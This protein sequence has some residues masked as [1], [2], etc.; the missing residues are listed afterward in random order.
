[1]IYRTL[2]V[3][4]AVL[5]A[6]GVCSTLAEEP[7]SAKLIEPTELQNRLKEAG[8]RI[9]DTRSNQAY[10]KSHVSGAAWVDVASWKELGKSKGGFRNTGVWGEKVGQLGLAVDSTVVVY[11]S[12]LSDTAR[13]WWLLKYLG[14]E[15][16]VI[17]DGGW[18]VWTEEGRPTENTVPTIAATRF[19]PRFDAD[20]LAEKDPLKDLL[21]TGKVTVVDT[22]SAAEFTGKDVRGKRGGHIPGA[23]HL[24]WK[25]LVAEDGRF[26]T[27]PQLQELFRKRGILRSKTAV[28]Y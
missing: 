18:K 17:L 16:V 27:V 8:L 28:C 20:R 26:K 11:G 21:G 4:F 15:R 1:M 3:V 23:T 10:A 2:L 19:V 22:R 24:E 25:E 14:V 6:A 5:G 9:L 13:I 7:K 12:K